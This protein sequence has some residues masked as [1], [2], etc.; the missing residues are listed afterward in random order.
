MTASR[1]NRRVGTTTVAEGKW[2]RLE[3]IEYLDRG[4]V[5]RTWEAAARQLGQGAVI[6][7]ARLLPSRRYILVEQYR[8]PVDRVV[9][10]FP[11]GLIDPNEPPPETAIRELLEETG[12]HGSIRRMGPLSYSSAGM[13]GEAVHLA[14]MNVDETDPRNQD[15]KPDLDDGEDIGVYLVPEHD[16]ASFVAQRQENGVV[17]DAKTEAFFLGAGLLE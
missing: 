1:G 15:P 16:I 12:Y 14:L 11:A 4:Q 3:R 9:L 10:E 8:P 5:K 17:L 13:S 6:M 2:L 7:I